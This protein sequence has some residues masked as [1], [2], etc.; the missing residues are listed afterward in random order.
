M[1]GIESSR[2]INPST[3]AKNPNDVR[4]GEGQYF[5]DIVP[6]TKTPAQLSKA[7]INNPYQGKKYNHFVAINVEG[8]DVTVGRPGVYVVLNT[9][10]LDVS[11]RIVGSGLVPQ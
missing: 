10:P 9:I 5:S 8:L 2:V 7:F 1:D 11:T 3:A 4:Y 6:G